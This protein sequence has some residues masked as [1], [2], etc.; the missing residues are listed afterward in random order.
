[1]PLDCEIQSFSRHVK[2]ES[3]SMSINEIISMYGDNELDLHPEF[4][5]F[6]RWTPEQK[7][8]FIESLIL[9]IP[10]PPVFVA[11]R[12]DATWDVIDGLQRLSTVLELRGILRDSGGQYKPPLCLTRT[13]YLTN[14]ES[15]YWSEEFGSQALTDTVKIKIKR[16]RIDVNIVSSGSD[17]E[18]KYEVFQRLNTGGAKA[19]DQEVRNCLLVM[20]NKKYFEWLKKLSEKDDF[21]G[22]ILMTDKSLDEAFD[23]E[24][25]SRFL[26]LSQ[27]SID[28]LKKIDELGSFLNDHCKKQA[29]N[30]EFPFCSVEYAFN[31]TFSFLENTLGENAFRRYSRERDNYTGPM[32]VS[33]FEVVAIGLGWHLYNGGQLPDP[34]SF[35]VRHQCLWQELQ[36]QQFVG[37]GVRSSTRIPATI[38]FGRKWV[39]E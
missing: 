27:R 26:V 2:T 17:P 16:A 21:R 7:S 22:C 4:Q 23:M 32:L 38:S 15:C 12:E 35:S 18:V 34:A 19:T 14:L 29:K 3:Y 30:P 6:F 13:H 33:L 25:V 20:H 11:E 39:A 5:R 31:E 8:R 9:G 28:E 24:L 1:M 37:S 36:K 10:I